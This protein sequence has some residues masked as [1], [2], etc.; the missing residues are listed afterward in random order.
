MLPKVPLIAARWLQAKMKQRTLKASLQTFNEKIQH[1][2]YQQYKHQPIKGNVRE[3]NEA[4]YYNI[5]GNDSKA[6]SVLSHNLDGRV[7]KITVN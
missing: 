6:N 2:V 7:L 3:R 4:L 1:P 5:R